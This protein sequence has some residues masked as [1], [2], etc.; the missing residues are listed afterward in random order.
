MKITI[1]KTT[2]NFHIQ[3]YV[4]TKKYQKFEFSLK[5]KQKKTIFLKIF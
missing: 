1:T 4:V 3:L 5:L 2:K